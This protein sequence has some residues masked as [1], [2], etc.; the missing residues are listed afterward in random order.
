MILDAANVCTILPLHVTIWTDGCVSLNQVQTIVSLKGFSGV[1]IYRRKKGELITIWQGFPFAHVQILSR[2]DHSSFLGIFG[3]FA[4]HR[5]VTHGSFTHLSERQPATCLSKNSRQEL[6][7]QWSYTKWI[8]MPI[9]YFPCYY[10]HTS[11]AFPVLMDDDF[12]D[13]GS[14]PLQASHSL[15]NELP[16]QKEYIGTKHAHSMVSFKHMH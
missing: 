2:H 12:L 14:I 4:Q 11:I 10:I 15:Q 13:C 7:C 3:T 9:P 6:V 16:R 1:H 5:K 8:A